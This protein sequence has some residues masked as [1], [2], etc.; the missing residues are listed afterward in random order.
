MKVQ[1]PKLTNFLSSTRRSC[2]RALPRPRTL[3]MLLACSWLVAG[4]GATQAASLVWDFD[5]STTGAQDGSGNWTNLTANSFWNGSANQTWADGSDAIF[6]SGSGSAGAYL[7]T[8]NLNAITAATLVFTNPGSYTIT[9]DGIDIGQVT[10]STAAGGA[11][12]FT[13]A[14]WVG[15]NVTAHLDVPFRN[16]NGS[17]MFVGPGG[18]LIF[19]QGQT[20]SQGGSPI[21][22]GA[23]SAVSTVNVT[24]GTWGNVVSSG[25]PSITGTMGIDGVTLNVSGT[26]VMQPGT[27]VD[28]GRPVTGSASDAVLNV[29]NGGQF[30]A[31]AGGQA[32]YGSDVNGNLQISRGGPATVNVSAGGILST[33]KNSTVDN[34]KFLLLPDS[35]SRA[36]LNVSGG[37]V[38][39]GTGP[40]AQPGVSSSTLNLITLMQGAMSYTVNALAIFNLSGGVVTAKG[41]QIGSTGG[42]FTAN[43][44]NQ[45]NLTGGTLYLDAPNITHPAGTGTNFALNVSGGTVAATANWSPA[46]SVPMNLANINGDVTFQAADANGSAYN[47]S[48]S[49]ALTGIG[50]CKKTGGGTLTLSGANNYAGATVVSNGTLVVSTVNAPAS[51]AVVVE[52]ANAASG[53]P[54]VS[55]LVANVGQHWTMNGN[56]TYNTGLPTADFNYGTYPPNTG[57]APVLVNGNLAFNVTPQVTVEGTLIPSGTYPLIKYTG[58]L[59]GTP[60][61]SLLFLPPGAVSATIVNNT[62]NKSLDLQI[63]STISPNLVWAAG[64]GAWDTGTLNWKQF[65]LAT[66]YNELEPVQ[67]DDTATGPFPITVTLATNHTPGSVLVNTTNA[68][69]LTGAGGVTGSC[70]LIKDGTGTL[71]LTGTNTY[72]GGTVAN[73]GT[74]NINFGGDGGADSAIGTGPLTN[75]LGSR[76]DNTS[77]HPVTLLPVIPEFWSDDF[78]FVGTTNFNTGPG[79]ITL[80]SGMVSLTVISNIFEVDG[81]I[82]DNGQIYGLGK[83]GGGTLVLSNYNAFSGGM[84][85]TAGTLDINADGAVGSGP[86]TISSGTFDNASG[87]PLTLD[88][89]SVI[90][91]NGNSSFAGSADLDLAGVPISILADGMSLTVVSNTLSTEGKVTAGNRT[92]NKNG[93]GTLTLGGSLG[94]A[95][96]GLG[97]NI[98]AGTV[99]L[100]KDALVNAINANPVTVN[101]AGTLVMENPTGTQF[102]Q[103]VTV[104]MNGGLWELNGDSENFAGL[105]FNSG[106][107][108]NSAQSLSTLTLVNGGSLSLAGTNCVFDVTNGTGAITIAGPITNRGSLFKTGAGLLTLVSNNTF[109]GSTIIAAGTLALA[110]PAAVG[111]GS[112]SN[113]VVVN[114]AAGATLDVSGRLDQ[115]FTLNTGQT[116]TGSGSVNGALVTVAGSTLSPG[117]GIG[118]LTVTNNITLGGTA[119]FELNRA[120][121]QTADELASVLGTITG[122]GILNVTNAGPALHAGDT[123]QLFPAAVTGFAAVNLPLT[124]TTGSSYTWTDHLAQD[125]TI[126]VATASSINPNPGPIQVAASGN[127]L[128]LSWPTNLGWILQAQTNSLSIGLGANWVSVPGSTAVATNV[129][130]INPANGSVFYRL[131]RPQ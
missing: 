77:G 90:T 3:Q 120:G 93:I 76:I 6:G 116:L 83:A 20:G 102:G 4:A 75:I 111:A 67:F 38:N 49:G 9:T 86:F 123:F 56:L 64:G 130:T 112:I 82:A 66:N 52:G 128:T 50:G 7:V 43:P 97:I 59:S 78:T 110:D 5:A 26:A 129:V 16:Q 106:V 72:T 103:L 85:L 30:L 121:A 105:T 71:T 65:G 44:T 2:L 48:L 23:G 89:P 99:N 131:V 46:C 53:L 117:T 98:N 100:N 14:L 34:G 15:T 94:T 127:T 19:S 57:I 119:V 125:G 73:N 60:P 21:F 108:R 61:T 95:N 79:G 31:N 41:I 109:S 58:A 74:L 12:G 62:A 69:V 37:I 104:T 70:G 25:A 122:G 92:I 8:N 96:S 51:G 113:S 80:G 88:T 63:V 39:V 55:A 10:W 126:T 68:Y 33:Y 18:T 47:I 101:A 1:P 32:G 45:V 91:F 17:D 87:A 24:N 107:V 29:N 28:I 36:L 42:T 118:T 22:K 115:T 54:V 13:K 84:T 27:R 11:G 35:T 40:N 114:I 81:Q 124:D